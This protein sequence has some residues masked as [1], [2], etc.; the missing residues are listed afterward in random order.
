MVDAVDR[1][2]EAAGIVPAFTDVTGQTRKTAPETRDAILSAM[3][4]PTDPAGAEAAL[5]EMNAGTLPAWHVAS[6][7]EVPSLVPR[8]P[9]QLTLEDGTTSEG[10]GPL[11]ALPLGRH[12]L[13]AD[14][15]A[16]WL[17]AAP[18]TLPLPPRGWGLMVPLYGL[19]PAETGGLGTY[20]DL[21]RMAEG[22][23][24][25]G[26]GFLG[27]NPVHAG[28]PTDPH[29][30]SPYSPSHRRRLSTL[31]VDVGG[32]EV[33]AD[34]PIDYATQI[35]AQNA[36]LDAAFASFEAAGGDQAFDAWQAAEGTALHDFALH[37]ALSEIHGPYWDRWP[38]ALQDPASAETRAAARDLSTRVRFH[39]WAQ[40]M[41]ETQLRAAQSRARAAGMTQGL[42]LDLAV[43]T[44]PH[45]AE[46]WEDRES[47]A[48]GTSL[49]APPD[50]FAA[51]G[52]T[53]GLAPFN[54]RR[55]IE[56]G[57]RALAETLARQLR[58]SGL[59]R[60]DHIL[61][62]D[63]AFWVPEGAP[64]AYVRMPRDAMLAVARIEAARAGATI[65]GEDLGN[66]PDGLGHALEASGILGCRLTM[67]ERGP[68]GAPRAPHDYPEAVVASFSTHD[69]PT[70][71]GW[72][73]GHDIG[74]RAALGH[75]DE[76]TAAGARAARRDE[77]RAL[78]DG[79]AAHADHPAEDAAR[80]HAHLAG[81]AARLVAVQ[82]ENVLDMPAQPNLPG[83]IADYPNWRQRLP[84]R[85]EAV[86]GDPRLAET[87]RIMTENGR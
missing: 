23:A 67:F 30:A 87:A 73:T 54:P 32:P 79:T 53:W 6:V 40:W 1:L 60:I 33:P 28:F 61:G 75:I 56:T 16:C 31:H 69:L 21:A 5:A 2:A 68:D 52:Q 17:L 65:V 64:G 25:H 44:H 45:G 8:G 58:L 37:Q 12:R 62:F 27:L 43:G 35:P 46:T 38:A 20:A 72:R 47:F 70:W 76:A 59:L 24:A 7:D 29:A 85:P 39:A 13:E 77:V 82:I 51:D 41:A 18:P 19:K 3:A 14:G 9:W 55:L 26:A 11:P 81:T 86:A 49:G 36:A 4:L 84:A 57:F 50:A 15:S 48:F 83:T 66:I 80:M 42:Y 22:T 78:D 63:R 74:A 10:T 71:A 34:G